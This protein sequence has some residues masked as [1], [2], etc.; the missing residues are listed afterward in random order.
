MIGMTGGEANSVQ[1]VEREEWLDIAPGFVDYNYEQSYDYSAAMAVRSGAVARFLAV[2]EGGRV[3]GAASVRLKRLPLLDRG[4]AYIS[5]GP[6]IHCHD[7]EGFKLDRLKTVV[8]A[9]KAMLVDSDRY[10]LYLR[11]A[12]TPLVDTGQLDS[13]L[14]SA[15][16]RKSDHVR[17]YS[18]VLLDLS[19]DADSLRRGLHQKW[20]YHLRRS[21]RECLDIDVGADGRASECF[22]GIYREMR[23]QKAFDSSLTPEFFIELP[24]EELGLTI[25][26][27]YRDGQP[28]GGHVLSILGN[29]AVY[30]F[31]ATN[32]VGRNVRAG[33]LL[34][35]AAMV[36][37]KAHGC[38]W[39]DLAGIDP[40]A[41]PGGY[42]FKTQMGGRIV[43]GLWGY[44]AKP[45]GLAATL[46]DMLLTLRNRL[47]A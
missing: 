19:Q 42:Q 12:T 16:L 26:I 30:L 43:E 34:H 44:G 25:L 9:L 31:G 28:V 27:A 11:P 1:I 39:Y 29:T 6:L 46:T 41:N 4:V 33:Y 40:I 21:E 47:K 8:T 10:N 5:G 15:G 24:K 37:A 32:D 18:T 3:I 22:M 38:R 23:Q 20:R 2:R 17:S 14:L 35:W 13:T 45:E 36:H 7:V